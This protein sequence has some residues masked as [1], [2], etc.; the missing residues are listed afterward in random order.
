MTLA[1]AAA[2]NVS[3]DL[4][5]IQR[6][7]TSGSGRHR[8]ALHELIRN[9][10]KQG[11]CVR[12]FSNRIRLDEFVKRVADEQTIRC[13]VAAGGDGTVRDLLNRH[14]D[15]PIAAM[16]MG[17]EN[18]VARHLGIPCDGSVVADVIDQGHFQFF[19]TVQIGDG[20]FLIMASAGF[21]ADI[22]HRL[23][24]GRTGNIHHW[25][26]L[27]PILSTIVDYRFPRIRVE[28][29]DTGDSVIGTYVL[30]GNFREYGL[31]VKLT[32]AAS[33]ADGQLDVCVFTS[34]S[35]IRTAM[36]FLRSFYRAQHGE[37][38]VRFQ[39]RHLR[40]QNA[41]SPTESR[42]VPLQT[43]GDPSGF[44]P[45][46]LQVKPRSMQLLVRD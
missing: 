6:N 23:H 26:Y 35:V 37:A 39:A 2:S 19:D 28:N 29:L 16:P 36:F 38:V 41:D 12:L 18:L 14:P 13:L 4:V 5:V 24:A 22:V 33:P 43:D 21:D 1:S 10:R 15:R 30:I 45:V 44:L 8:A 42:S 7:P 9:L 17:T 40:L 46:E 20:R 3:G 34:R 25:N 32:P 27:R 31:N 11:Y